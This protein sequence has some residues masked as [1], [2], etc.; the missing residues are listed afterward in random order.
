MITG[1]AVYALR[2]CLIP[3]KESNPGQLM[4]GMRRDSLFARLACVTSTHRIR[5]LLF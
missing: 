2:T 1:S 4:G 5:K 3:A